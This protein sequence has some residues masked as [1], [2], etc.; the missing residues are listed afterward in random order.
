MRAGP[1]F[2]QAFDFN[3]QYN[4]YLRNVRDLLD[5]VLVIPGLRALQKDTIREVFKPHLLENKAKTLAN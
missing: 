3:A 1:T 5:T 4:N 2:L